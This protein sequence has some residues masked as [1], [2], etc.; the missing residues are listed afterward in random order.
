M[1]E[2]H[3]PVCATEPRKVY[4]DGEQYE[5][6]NDKCPLGNER[7][8]VKTFSIFMMQS[9]IESLKEENAKLRAVNEKLIEA[10]HRVDKRCLKYHQLP[11]RKTCAEVKAPLCHG[12]FAMKALAEAEKIRGQI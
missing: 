5:C 12:C 7:L 4:L 3:C 11:G 9:E 1:S 10:L 8:L 2:L 6:P